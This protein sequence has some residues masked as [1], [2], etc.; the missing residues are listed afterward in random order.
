MTN[1]PLDLSSASSQSGPSEEYLG[2]KRHFDIL[3]IQIKALTVSISVSTVTHQ[4]CDARHVTG[5]PESPLH[6]QR[7]G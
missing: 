3:A 7:P 6:V 1:V 2:N 5:P 4:M